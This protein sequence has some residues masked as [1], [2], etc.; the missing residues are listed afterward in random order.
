MLTARGFSH[1]TEAQ[2]GGELCI[3]HLNSSCTKPTHP[4]SKAMLV[5]VLLSCISLLTVGLN[6]LVIISISHFR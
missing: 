2:E 3:P 4:P 5:Y 6:L 1:E